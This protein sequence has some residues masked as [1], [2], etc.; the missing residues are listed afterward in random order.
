MD[1][2]APLEAPEP[3]LRDA[4]AQGIAFDV[5]DIE[6]LGLFLALLLEANR[7]FNL[8]AITDA[9][10]AWHKHVLDSLSL[11]KY[12]AASEAKRVV[13]VGSGGGFPGM[14]LAVA[15]PDVRFCLVEATGKKARFLEQAAAALAL[16]NVEVICE[17][18]ETIGQ[19]HKHHR[20]QYD[21]V[22]AR[23]VG[24]LEVLLE[25]TV[26]LA[27]VGGHV[28][29]IK[30]ERAAAEIEEAAEALRLLHAEVVTADRTPT[31]TVVCI[32]KVGPTPRTYPRRPGEPKRAPIK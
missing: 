7:S 23:A 11:L 32:E 5:G 20:A 22:V 16:P 19:D 2:P 1:A 13:D 6:R 24:P 28:L 30:G 17:R 8:T 21:A 12:L 18:A 15:L 27:R 14:P 29:A 31:G 9:E 10:E 25:L 26:P 4:E 3:F